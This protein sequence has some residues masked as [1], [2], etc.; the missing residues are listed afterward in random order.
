MFWRLFEICVLALGPQNLFLQQSLTLGPLALPTL[1]PTQPLL[2][3][4]LFYHSQ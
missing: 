3:L 4:L 1:D 2:H